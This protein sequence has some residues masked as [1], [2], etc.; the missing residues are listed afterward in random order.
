[1]KALVYGHENTYKTLAA[2]LQ[3]EGIEMQKLG[4]NIYSS[5][6]KQAEEKYDLAIVDIRAD[7]TNKACRFIRENWN[8]PLV[9]IVDPLQ[10]DWKGL[11]SIEADGY[12]SSVK[13]GKELSA[14][15]R[16]LLRRLFVNNKFQEK[17]PG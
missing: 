9:L 8:I 1:M 3:S 7:N 11:K 6:N 13:K 5:G 17:I 10:A 16:A 4:D 2:S 15:S 12:I 14:R